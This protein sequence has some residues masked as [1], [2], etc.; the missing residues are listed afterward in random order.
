L[1]WMNSQPKQI[2]VSIQNCCTK[3]VF[4]VPAIH[5]MIT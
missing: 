4:Q 3:Y 1:S 2:A 5:F